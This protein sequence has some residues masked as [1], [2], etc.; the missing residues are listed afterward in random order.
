MKSTKE[1]PRKSD[2]LIQSPSVDRGRQRIKRAGLGGITGVIGKGTAIGVSL[3]SVPLTVEYLGP[4]RYGIW[5]TISSFVAWMSIS[6]AGFGSALTNAL[7]E[8]HGFRDR[9]LAQGLVSTAFWTLISIAIFIGFLGFIL[10][11]AINWFEILNISPSTVYADEIRISVG[12][13]G[14]FFCLSFPPG[15]VTAIYNGYQEVHRGNLWAIAGNLASLLA[16]LMVVRIKGGLPF[17]I[18]A[19]M[20]TMTFVRF[21]N[22]VYLF[23][24]EHPYLKPSP[25]FAQRVHLRRLWNLGVYYLVQQVGNIGMFQ[26]QPI[27]LT[28]LQG[29]QAVGPFSVAYK[30]LTL[31]QYVLILLLNPLIGAYGEARAQGDWIWIRHTLLWSVAGSLSVIIIT[32]APLALF[33]EWIISLWVGQIMLTDRMTIYWLAIYVIA[34]GLATP[35]AIFLQGLERA[36]DIAVLTIFNGI[37][38]VVGAMYLI[39]SFGMRGMAVA[40]VISLI[41]INC[42]YQTA[43]CIRLASMPQARHHSES[44]LGVN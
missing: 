37:L 33:S 9:H 2:Y 15:L 7:A 34:T 42:T 11:P 5:V 14:L 4:D 40:M 39:P 31:P 3:I 8:A 41:A 22:M 44:S 28:Q 13:A 27:L 32:V 23:F 43:A 16:L 1:H 29:P 35:L 24:V 12:L 25:R 36:R 18:F 6:D 30:L 19:L 17:L 10:I 38:T 20:G 26:A 21:T